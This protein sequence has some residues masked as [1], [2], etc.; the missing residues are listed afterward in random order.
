[1]FGKKSAARC[2][3]AGPAVTDHPGGGRPS[4]FQKITSSDNV[5]LYVKNLRDLF[6]FHRLH[7]CCGNK[8]ILSRNLNSGK[9]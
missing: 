3:P 8:Y 5:F 2:C 9:N 6:C 4:R 7:T 1:M